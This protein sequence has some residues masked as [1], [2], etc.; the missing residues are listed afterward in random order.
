MYVLGGIMEKRNRIGLKALLAIMLIVG[1]ALIS[2]CSKDERTIGGAA[3][4]AGT[5]AV[6]GSAAGGTGGAVAGGLIGAVAGGLIG[7]S[8]GDD[9]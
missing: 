9:D 4:G 1:A 6:I 7:R 5:G 8:T 3:I 2:G